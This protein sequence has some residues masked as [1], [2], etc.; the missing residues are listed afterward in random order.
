[1]SGLKLRCL[2]RWLC[3]LG[4]IGLINGCGAKE[5]AK[6]SEVRAPTRLMQSG[7]RAYHADRYQVATETFTSAADRADAGLNRSA[8]INARCWQA[9]ALLRRGD[10][11][12]ALTIIDAA[13]AIRRSAEPGNPLPPELTSRLILLRVVALL[14]QGEPQAARN[15][16]DRLAPLP[17]DSPVPRIDLLRGR[18]AVALGELDTAQQTLGQVQRA[19]AD[20]PAIRAELLGLRGRI[21]SKRGRHD[22]AAA[23]FQQQAR[24]LKRQ[25]DHFA[26]AIALGQAGEAYAQAD[27]PEQ[28]AHH[29]ARAGR[30]LQAM[31]VLDHRWKPLLQAG[32]K[33]AK[34]AKRTDL[35]ATIRRWL[36]P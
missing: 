4:L 35:A 26:A 6:P 16:M 5:L 17:S 29:L 12:E 31:E 33:Q 36:N 2:T 32:L 25:Q 23:W 3:V 34:L 20:A 9:A 24:R 18:I 1:V 27:Q 28:A 22:Q 15:A 19:S 7:Q 10:A 21:A 11:D 8:A 14:E 30:A 13:E